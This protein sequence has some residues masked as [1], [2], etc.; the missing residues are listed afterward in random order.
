MLFPAYGLEVLC[1]LE[2]SLG[3][4]KEGRYI[5]Q[6]SVYS[7]SAPIC[8][9]SHVAADFL[10]SAATFLFLWIPKVPLFCILSD[11][12]IKTYSMVIRRPGG[13]YRETWKPMCPFW[14]LY[15]AHDF[16]FCRGASIVFGSTPWQPQ[17]KLSKSSAPGLLMPVLR[18]FP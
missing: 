2:T 10:S 12:T 14:G 13:V 17:P 4:V 15:M 5:F 7:K 16:F 1:L 6:K 8:S 9:C 11:G 3:L 18:N